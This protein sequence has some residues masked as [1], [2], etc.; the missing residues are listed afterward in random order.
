MTLTT[1]STSKAKLERA[2]AKSQQHL[3]SIQHQDGYWWGELESNVTITAEVVLLHKIWQ[4]DKTRPLNKAEAY[5]RSQ[6]REHGGWELYYGDGGDLS[7][8]VEAYMALRLLGVPALDPALVKAK[9]FILQRGG[10]SKSRIFTKMHLALIG[11][12]SWRGLP[13]IPPWIMLLPEDSPFT[14]YEMSSW[15]RG[16]TVPLLIVFDRQPVFNLDTP[17]TL[18]ELYTEGIDNIVYELPRNHDW[19]DIFLAIDS[20]FQFAR[21]WNLVPLREEGL[22]AAEK[23][24]LERQEVTGDWGGIIPAMLNSLLSLRTLNYDVNDPI[25]Q[26]GLTAIDNFAIEEENSYRIQPCIS[27]VWDT[28]WCLRALIESGIEPDSPEM[29]KAGN[30]LLDKQILDYGDW[31]FKNRG[32]APG[33]WAFEFEN[34][35]YPDLDDSAVV[36][37]GLS[38]TK[39]PDEANKAQAIA[40]CV[41]WMASMQCKPGGW[42]AFDL[43]NDQDWINLIPYGDLKA[44]IDPNTADVTARVLEMLGECNLSIDER[45]IAKAIAY[46][47]DEQEPDGSWF[48]RWGVNYIYGTSGVLSALSAISP[49]SCRSEIQRGATW[50]VNCQNPDGGWGE[51]CA[52]YDNPNLKGMGD[53]TASQT[54]W[55]IIGI[56]AA[57]DSIEFA[58]EKAIAKG[59]EYL[60]RTQQ[61]DGTWDE[62]FFTGTGF[63]GHFYLKYHLYQQYFPLQAL[64]RSQKI[65][66][67]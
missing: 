10:I 45:Q 53:S 18:D 8:S 41:N 1:E 60:I 30:W 17:I 43:D 61:D 58:G 40:R 25:I 4:T 46:L 65:I 55:A 12:Y 42:A 32:V 35:F 14:I 64:A 15:A 24:V 54:A 48:G 31:A 39:L 7:T 66:S 50:L 3:L 11:C 16:S 56:L 67:N 51:T 26:R 27:P 37:M 33:G 62:D 20:A 9:K 22:A 38:Q 21:D 52:S 19:T 13:S 34:R 57:M 28:A 29:V 23:W 36:V 59:V 47:I 49:G 2:I 63:P 44:M 6:Q 5:L